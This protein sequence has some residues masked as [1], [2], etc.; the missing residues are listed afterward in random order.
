VGQIERSARDIAATGWAT[1]VVACGSNHAL[2][3]R[4][5]A[6][7]VGISLGWVTDMPTL[8][9]ACD[10]VI[11]NAGGLTCLEALTSGLPVISYRCLPGHGRANAAAL[12]QAGWCTW[13]HDRR[14]LAGALEIAL[15]EPSPP[16]FSQAWS[17]D[18]GV[19]IDRLVQ[20]SAA[21]RL[22]PGEPPL[23][24]RP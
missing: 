16:L 6:A 18:S 4:L 7:G 24:V 22:E 12:E 17:E 11:Q 13:A 15:T 19:L 2:R 14:Q 8:M 5:E 9:Q 10:V 21:E 20:T 1:P 3:V 23:A